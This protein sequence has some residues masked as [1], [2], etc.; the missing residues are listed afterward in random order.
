MSP[1]KND[2]DIF[3]YG[4][5]KNYVPPAKNKAPQ[6]KGSHEIQIRHAP[7]IVVVNNESVTAKMAQN[8]RKV[9]TKPNI[10]TMSH[11]TSSNSVTTNTVINRTVR[12][13]RVNRKKVTNIKSE[14]SS[15]KSKLK[16]FENKLKR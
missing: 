12:K 7:R 14:I 11:K 3:T 9:A 16:N 13:P 4:M 15:L 1:D 5:P 8:H 10:V 2:T 6:T